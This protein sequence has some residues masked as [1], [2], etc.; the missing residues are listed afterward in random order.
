MRLEGAA[1]CRTAQSALELQAAGMHGFERG[2]G[3]VSYQW[4]DDGFVEARL[5]GLI[6]PA[7]AGEL[8]ALLLDAACDPDTAGV[9]AA[10]QTAMVALPP[11]DPRHYSYVPAELR[12]VPLAVLVS[13]QQLHVYMGIAQAAATAGAIRRAFLSRD[14]ARS[15]LREQAQALAANRV[16]RPVRQSQP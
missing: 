14:E 5:T 2:S 1:L 8:S 6:V 11:I 12:G 10:V 4:V 7:N 3:R 15:W 9:L 13:P 16:W